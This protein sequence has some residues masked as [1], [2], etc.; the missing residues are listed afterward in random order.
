MP[1]GLTAAVSSATEGTVTKL[2]LLLQLDLTTPLYLYSGWPSSK[3]V[4]GHTWEAGGFD[5]VAYDENQNG[6]QRA[7][8]LVPYSS[9]ILGA[10]GHE[11]LFL[12]DPPDS[13]T[14]SLWLYEIDTNFRDL[15]LE[16]II[17]DGN[18]DP[19]GLYIQFNLAGKINGRKR[20]P[21]ERWGPPAWNRVLTA[22][23]VIVWKQQKYRAVKG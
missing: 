19:N 20:I 12:T 16:G 13:Q 3:A 21:R 9:T 15:I 6:V 4:Y 2:R 10:S 18:L 22:G 8:V 7:T 5:L 1:R 11:G 23:T 14:C 17:E